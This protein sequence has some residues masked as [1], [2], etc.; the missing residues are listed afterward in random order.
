MKYRD[1]MKIPH[2]LEWKSESWVIVL[3]L[4]FLIMWPWANHFHRA[5]NF[6]FL[7][8][9]LMQILVKYFKIFKIYT[10]KFIWSIQPMFF[11]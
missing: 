10:A 8:W 1:R 9:L 3:D 2:T 11:S 4:S 7:I 5:S 6:L